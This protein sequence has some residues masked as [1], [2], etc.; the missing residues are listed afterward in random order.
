MPDNNSI[1]QQLGLVTVNEHGEPEFIKSVFDLTPDKVEQIKRIRPHK[2]GIRCSRT[3]HAKNLHYYGPGKAA[4][5]VPRGSCIECGAELVD[6]KE[7]WLRDA[8]DADKFAFLQTEWIRHFFFNV[9]ITPRIEKYA[10]REGLS[11]LATI[12]EHQL[13]GERMLRFG[14]SWRE[15]TQTPMLRGTIVHWARHALACCCRQCLS[16]WHNVPL[17][18]TLDAGDVEYFKRL[19]MKY[20][21]RRFPGI[22]SEAE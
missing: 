9:P 11:G 8:P 12:A 18:H 19:I 14:S 5:W 7:M 16:Y 10:L 17:D 6:W 20:I 1:P 22:G 15:S 13:Q 2:L 21:L 4:L 3:D